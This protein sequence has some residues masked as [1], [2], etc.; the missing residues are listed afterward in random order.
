MRRP[1]ASLLLLTLILGTAL[2]SIPSFRNWKRDESSSSEEDVFEEE[3]E[4]T[5]W[6]LLV[7]GSN[8]WYNYRHQADVCHS[9]HVLQ[10][11]GVHHDHIITMMYDDIANSPENKFPGQL[12]NAPHG[13]DVYKSVKIDYSGKDVNADNFLA[14]LQGDKKSVKGGNGRVVESNKNDKVFVF[15]SDHGAVGLIAFPSDMLTV[16]QLNKVLKEMHD[17]NRYKELTFYLEACESGSMFENILKKDINVYAITAANAHESSWGCFCDNDM[18]LPCLGDQ[19][20]VNWMTDSDNKSDLNAETLDDQFKV[21][22]KLTDKSHV[23]H[24]G[25]MDIAQEKVSEFQGHDKAPMPIFQELPEADMSRGLWDVREI[26]IMML[27]K[28]IDQSND[29]GEQERLS[30]QIQMIHQKRH[31]LYERMED[32]VQALIHDPNR[33]RQMLKKHPKHGVTQMECHHDVVNA[34]H[35]ACFNFNDNPYAMKYVYVLA[36]LCEERLSV[37]RIVQVFTDQCPD[38]NV[39][40]IE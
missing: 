11:H 27:R 31:Y 3:G 28:K 23:M 10:A 35:R 12:F 33:Q 21:V 8:G 4:G 7:A 9:Y 22:K 2:G 17:K 6:A 40:G 39:T 38:I 1:L 37:E 34:F 36:N 26:P 5:I 18:G 20:S 15:F 14:I 30:K 29:E 24:Y 16:K 32:I 25:D 13:G 19:F